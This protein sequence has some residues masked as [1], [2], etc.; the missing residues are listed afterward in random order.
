[1][2]GDSVFHAEESSS[3]LSH[4]EKAAKAQKLGASPSKQV[5]ISAFILCVEVVAKLYVYMSS[6]GANDNNGVQPFVR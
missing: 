6:V 3:H 1:M 4:K 5:G 2:A